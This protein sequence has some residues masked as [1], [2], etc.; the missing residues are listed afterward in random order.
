MIGMKFKHENLNEIYK[1]VE[2]LNKSFLSLSRAHYQL[3]SA[4]V[5]EV[6]PTKKELE[7][8]KR[9]ER[10]VPFSRVKK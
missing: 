10:L 4:L 9:K 1:K 8:V 6:K 5:P 2:R 3:M 7:A